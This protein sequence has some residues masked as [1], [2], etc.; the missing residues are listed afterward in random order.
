MGAYTTSPFAKAGEP[1]Y[2]ITWDGGQNPRVHL[3]TPKGGIEFVCS[4]MEL[5]GIIY[6]IMGYYFGPY[7]MPEVERRLESGEKLY[8]G[9]DKPGK[10]MSYIALGEEHHQLMTHVYSA[11]VEV[12]QRHL[13]ENRLAYNQTG[14]PEHRFMQR[15]ART[16]KEYFSHLS[17]ADVLRT[18]HEWLS[19]TLVN[20]A[21]NHIPFGSNLCFAGGSALNI[22]WN[23]ALRRSGHFK[24][25]W[26]PPFPND[27]GSAIGTA[28]CEMATL[29]NWSMDW[30]VY[31]GPHLKPGE[32]DGLRWESS[33]CTLRQLARIFYCEPEEPVVFLNE[34]A[35]IGPRALGNRSI[36]CAATVASNKDLLNLLKQRESFR[37]VAPICLEEQAQEIF[38]PGT[39]DPYMLFDHEVRDFYRTRIPAV[40][41]LDNTAR[42]QTVNR[43]QN[44]NVHELLTQYRRLSSYPLLCNTSANLNGS[45]FF[46]DVES[47]MRWGRTKYIWANGFLYTNQ[48]Y[49][50]GR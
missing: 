17:D 44:F 26:V 7:K 45:G 47:A 16:V 2:V 9:Y 20:R 43:S 50:G 41:H 48:N 39:P 15:I 24:D 38:D 8:G 27:C 10:L 22:K 1:A 5:Y 3:V 14:T 12:L 46:P 19:M 13:P 31:C 29:G 32:I 35:E 49:K 33:N 6:G 11:Y 36:L 30:N 18:I 23:S 25:V 42:L 40:I 34:R 37:P 21:E 28:A 4:L